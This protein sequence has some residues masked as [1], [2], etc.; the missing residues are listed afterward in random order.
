MRR[1]GEGVAMPVA[2]ALTPRSARLRMRRPPTSSGC[3]WPFP[4]CLVYCICIL[5]V[6]VVLCCTGFSCFLLWTGEETAVG[7]LAPRSVARRAGAQAD[8]GESQDTFCPYPTGSSASTKDVEWCISLPLSLSLSVPLSL[9]LSL[10]LPFSVPLSLP[11]SLSPSL[12]SSLS[13]FV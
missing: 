12:S 13:S 4:F 9:P 8:F 2:R 6:E 1:H 5:C 7:R 3:L 11:L 10:S